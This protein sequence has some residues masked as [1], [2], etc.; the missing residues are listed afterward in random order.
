MLRSLLPLLLLCTLPLVLCTAHPQTAI[1]HSAQ[2]DDAASTTPPLSAVFNCAALTDCAACISATFDWADFAAVDLVAQPPSPD[3]QSPVSALQSN[4][5]CGWCMSSWKCLNGDLNG[6]S[7]PLYCKS[8][9]LDAQQTRTILSSRAGAHLMA[10]SALLLLLIIHVSVSDCCIRVA[11][12]ATIGASR[13]ARGPLT[14]AVATAMRRRAANATRPTTD[15][16]PL[17]NAS[18]QR[19]QH[20]PWMGSEE[21]IRRAPFS[22][23]RLASA[24]TLGWLCSRHHRHHWSSRCSFFCRCVSVLIGSIVGGVLLCSLLVTC[25]VCYRR[26]RLARESGFATFSE[27]YTTQPIAHEH[28]YHQYA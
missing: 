23:T 16:R 8:V 6:P 4:K 19:G 18:S 22:C 17:S 20:A 11:G 15:R 27:P 28:A 24:L 10:D 12:T 21:R 3:E 5:P 1:K 13:V 9:T 14:A 7:A 25:G 2:P 26:R